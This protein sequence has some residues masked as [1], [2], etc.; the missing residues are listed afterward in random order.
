M[1][2]S[3]SASVFKIAES[4]LVSA[5]TSKSPSPSHKY[6]SPISFAASPFTVTLKV[7]RLVK[8]SVVDTPVSYAVWRSDK[9][10]AEGA[11]TST[12]ID[13]AVLEE[14][15]F[16]AESSTVYVMF[17]VPSP[18]SESS[19]TVKVIKGGSSAAK[20]ETSS[21][22]VNPFNPDRVTL[23]LLYASRPLIKKLGSV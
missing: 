3:A 5:A 12:V 8:L 10:G 1:I 6:I 16:P 13:K 11:V 15:I 17:H 19:G 20:P 21:V 7:F 9:V 18:N 2:P 23:S 4:I 22:V 14:V